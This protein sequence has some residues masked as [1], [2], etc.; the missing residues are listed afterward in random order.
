MTGRARP[1]GAIARVAVL[2]LIRDRSNL[3]FV[4]IFPLLLILLIGAQFGGEQGDLTLAVSA[5]HVG[6]L[7]DEVVA[8]IEEL[9]GVAV[10]RH[11]S[12]TEVVDAVTSGDATGGLVVPDGY[13]GAIRRSPQGVVVQF[14]GRPDSLSSALQSVV[15]PV[16]AD[17]NQRITLA[18]L[19]IVVDDDVSYDDALAQADAAIAMLPEFGVDRQ[20]IGTDQLEEA[21]AGLGQFDLGAVQQLNLFVFLASLVNATAL[22][23]SREYGV[24][25]RLLA[26]PVSAGQ[27]L[28]GEALGRYGVALVQ[29]LY[30]VVGTLLLFQVD[31]GDP[32]SALVILALFAAASAGA[33]LLLGAVARTQAQAGAI[34]VGLGIGVAALG[35]SMLPVEIMPA[36]MRAISWLTPHA[37]SYDAFA[38][39]VR[40]G[41]TVVDVLP[42]L[43]VLAAMAVV[44]MSV[45]ALLLRRTLT[46]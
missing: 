45:A 6:A 33:G 2:R 5:G 14:V 26:H 3:F 28:R 13:D 29:G 31:W 40:R 34:G 18:D 37:W 38:E 10:D 32:T 44:L 9:D 46:H 35:G 36:G 24:T 19:V 16:I 8:Q 30:I 11:G 25:R 12:A 39:V 27:V 4:F 43:G 21:F 17:Q 1:T 41:G 23:Q 15:A 7:G 42:Q 22:I 20:E